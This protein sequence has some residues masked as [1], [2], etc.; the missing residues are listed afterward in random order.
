ME[1]QMN[2]NEKELIVMEIEKYNQ[3]MDIMNGN[4]KKNLFWLGMFSLL[5]VGSFLVA[6]MDNANQTL[7]PFILLKGVA[8][9][10]VS[11]RHLVDV[12]SSLMKKAGLSHQIDELNKLL[13]LSET[14]GK[15]R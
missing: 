5:A 8:E 14:K 6:N 1:G 15:S 2:Q 9:I 13:N 4:V 10:G 12:I 11:I 7:K 3:E